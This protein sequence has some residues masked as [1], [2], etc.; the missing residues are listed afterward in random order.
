MTEHELPTVYELYIYELFKFVLTCIREEH[1]HKSL[2]KML[3]PQNFNYSLRSMDRLESS[4]PFG[5]TKK[6][7]HS[8]ATQ[9][10]KLYNNLSRNGILLDNETIKSYSLY[11]IIR[12]R[13]N[14]KIFSK[15][16]S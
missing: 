7:Y 8:L 2:N 12:Y 4:V 10:P 16:S 6:F 5:N 11:Q 3:T 14:F 15:V 13:Y 1:L 9:I